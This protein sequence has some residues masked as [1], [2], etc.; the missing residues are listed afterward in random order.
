[1]NKINTIKKGISSTILKNADKSNSIQIKK[2]G[3]D[4]IK[5]LVLDD[6]LAKIISE[7]S[8]MEKLKKN[9]HYELIGRGNENNILFAKS[10]TRN[11]NEIVEKIGNIFKDNIFITEGDLINNYHRIFGLL[12]QNGFQSESIKLTNS[13]MINQIDL[14]IIFRKQTNRVR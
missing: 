11:I 6:I 4:L 5:P 13:G 12:K 3:Y 14:K 1:M 9:L 10:F 2:A 8:N 7:P